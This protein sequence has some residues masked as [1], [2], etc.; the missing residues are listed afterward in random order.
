VLGEPRSFEENIARY[1]ADHRSR[2]RRELRFFEIQRSLEDAV[3]RAALAEMPSGKRFRH[4]YRIPRASLEKAASTLLSD[5]SRV[6]ATTTFE[7]LHEVV[8]HLTRGIPKIGELTVYDTALRIGAYLGLQP[9]K[10]FV[11]AGTR[12]GAQCL[13]LNG[14]RSTIEMNSHRHSECSRHERWRTSCA[15]IRTRSGSL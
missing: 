10:V 3:R 14:K 7:E 15:S 9:L 2:A 6:S 13:G 8:E 12:R 11:H 1:D 4:Q 5:L